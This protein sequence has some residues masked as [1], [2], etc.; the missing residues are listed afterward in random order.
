MRTLTIT[1]CFASL[2]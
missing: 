1:E 2:F